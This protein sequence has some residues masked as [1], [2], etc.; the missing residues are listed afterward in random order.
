[1]ADRPWFKFWAGDFLTDPLIDRTPDDALVL[2]LKMRSV[3]CLEGS[4]SADPAEIARKTRMVRVEPRLVH[5][6]PFFVQKGDQ[7]FDIQLEKDKAWSDRGRKGANVVNKRRRAAQSG[8]A[9]DDAGDDSSDDLSDA[10]AKVD[11]WIRSGENFEERFNEVL[12]DV[13]ASAAT[14]GRTSGGP[15]AAQRVRSSD[16]R[17]LEVKSSEVLDVRGE[18]LRSERETKPASVESSKS[19]QNVSYVPCG[20]S[21]ENNHRMPSKPTPEDLEHRRQLLKNQVQNLQRKGNGN[22]NFQTQGKVKSA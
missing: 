10:H 6:M 21:V 14:S 12:Q 17:G 13:E 11:A 7:L 22:T 15:S 18:G 16:V 20:T 5:C 9:S 2:M 8:A 19:V 4:I 1:M 3:C